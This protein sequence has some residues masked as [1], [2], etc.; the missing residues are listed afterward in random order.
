MNEPSPFLSLLPLL[1][2]TLIF[3]FLAI[4]IS[5]RKGK[6]LGYAVLCL[7]PFLSVFVLLYW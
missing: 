1:L 4:P 5:R 3:F 7:V 2:V 6:N